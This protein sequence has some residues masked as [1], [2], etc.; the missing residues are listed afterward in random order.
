M[1]KIYDIELKAVKEF[2]S[3]DGITVAANIYFRNKKVGTYYNPGN[4]HPEEITF[5]SKEDEEDV[6]H[7]MMAYGKANPDELWTKLYKDDEERY[8]QAVE[9]AKEQMPCLKDEEL[10]IGNVDYE[11]VIFAEE[12]LRLRFLEKEFKK[13]KKKGYSFI[14]VKVEKGKEIIMMFPDEYTRE[15]AM[16]KYECFECYMSLE[17]FIKTPEQNA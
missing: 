6:I 2:P 16:Q 15:D 9:C 11:F 1:A 3:S 5:V 17:D 10:C 7:A 12:I 8:Q 13:A 14:G 4:G